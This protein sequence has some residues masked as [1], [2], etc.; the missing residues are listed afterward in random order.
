[1]L[2]TGAETTF[3]LII[4]IAGARVIIKVLGHQH[5]WLAGGYNRETGLFGGG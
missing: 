4:T 2:T 5:R 1:M 3:T